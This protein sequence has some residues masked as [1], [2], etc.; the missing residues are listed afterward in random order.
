MLKIDKV[1]RIENVTVYG[2]DKSDTMHYLVADTPSY[3]RNED[4]TLAFTFLSYRTPRIH[5]DGKLGGGFL[6][7]D[8]ELTVPKEKEDII[9]ARLQEQLDARFPNANPKPQVEFGSITWMKGSASIN[10][11]NGFTGFV[12]KVHNP[13]HPSYYGKLLTPFT[14]ELTPEGSTLLEQ[15]LTGKGGFVQVMYDLWALVKLPAIHAE[16]WFS[17]QNFSSF[18]QDWEK[19]VH[20]EG[21]FGNFC[22]WL[23]GGDDTDT[24]TITQTISEYAS[25]GQWGGV[26][27]HFDAALPDPKL[28]QEMQDKVRTWAFDTLRQAMKDMLADPTQPVSEEQRKIPPDVTTFKQNISQFHWS[29]FRMS[30]NEE[31]A[32]MM[33]LAPQGMLEPITNMKD[34]DG[35]PIKWEDYSRKIDLN[36]PFFQNIDVAVRANA[37]F[38]QLPI[39]SIVVTLEYQQ[40]NI[41]EVK[42]VSLTSPDQIEHFRTFIA[43]G[44][45]EYTY[46]YQVNYKGE[47]QNYDS[48]PRQSKD[49]VLTINVGD[50]G[51]LMVDGVPGDIN[52]SQVTQAAVMLRYDGNGSGPVERQ[53][54]LDKSH[55]SFSVREVVFH[56]VTDPYRYTVKYIMSDGREFSG[57]EQQSRSPQLVI[58]D[59]FNAM[60]TVG[61]RAAGNLDTE[62]NT[63]FVDLRYVDEANRYDKTASVA[64]SK[65]QPFFDWS[66]PVISATGGKVFYSANIQYKDG[67]VEAVNEREATSNTLMVGPIVE[68]VVQ[69]K[70]LA[71]LID[72]TKVSLVQVSLH[73]SDP[74]NQIDERIDMIFEPTNKA[75]QTWTLPLKDKTKTKYSYEANFFMADGSTLTSEAKDTDQ[76]SIVL[77]VPSAQVVGGR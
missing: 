67:R 40:G 24:T 8:S 61:V 75:P 4:G 37:D 46:R 50:T 2:D 69:I 49:T 12:E 72:F 18:V 7:F 34:K 56:P 53:F 38:K 68:D 27:L 58:N 47:S 65:A 20:K 22:D 17:S 25:K 52:F 29:S 15:A 73:Y 57:G 62:I 32:V 41:H 16:V 39:D 43:D 23:F 70:V 77:R 74:A 9:R 11:E 3:R 13:G 35:N 36:D 66:F 48:G 71:N 45:R 76:L 1:Q 63:I 59:V 54:M 42:T 6:V 14:V 51:V 60:K 26:E 33:N 19:Q 10:L 21:A 28:D 55:P 44:K 5:D 64:L 30:F 31:H